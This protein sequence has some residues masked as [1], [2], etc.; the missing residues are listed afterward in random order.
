MDPS[1]Q[2]VLFAQVVDAG[3]FSAVARDLNQ[4]PSAVS[5][6]MRHLEDRVG[7]RLLKR[8]RHGVVPTDEGKSF[9]VRCAEIS[10]NVSSALDLM[11][12]LTDH[13]QGRLTVV[14]TV[15]F[16]KSQV[17]PILPG[18]LA[19]YP[20]VS[21]KLEFTDRRISFED[22]LIDVAVQFG[23]QI[24]DQSLV[25]RKLASNRRI[26]CAAPAYLQRHGTPRTFDDLRH[27]NVLELST[28][29][30]WNDWAWNGAQ[31]HGDPP[32]KC[33]FEAN[34]GDALHRAALAGIGITLASSY[35]IGPDLAAGRL[36][37]VLPQ[38]ED[39]GSSLYAVYSARRNLSPKVR[40]FIDHLVA[41]FG[42]V[43]P[44]ERSGADV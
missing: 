36:V 33:T 7:V 3:S 37:R 16:G 13:P 40:A 34:S 23:E 35:L 21:L 39:T 1:G 28:I 6:Q 17:L 8:S 19:A 9:Y 38:V 42:P 11:A 41:C 4:S 12:S 2:M 24:E 22:G 26:V 31:P 29:A 30:G 18:F 43:P 32:Y 15:A 25:A 44:W 27:H 10:Q 5:K 20:D 14:S